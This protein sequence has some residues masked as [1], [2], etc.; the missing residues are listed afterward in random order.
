MGKTLNVFEKASLD[1]TALGSLQLF[2]QANLAG[3]E[4]LLSD[5][6]TLALAPGEALITPGQP[7]QVVYLVLAGSLKV[8]EGAATGSP[9]GSIGPGECIGLLSLIDR[10]P[11]RVH[12]VCE[13]QC[14]LLALDEDRLLALFNTPTAI[15]RNALLILMQ[16]LRS[17]DHGAPERGQLQS[18]VARNSQV[19]LVTGIHNQRW[20]DEMVDRLILRSAKDNKP[21]SVMAVHVLG[22]EEFVR[23]FGCEIGDQAL[24]E[25]ARTINQ[26][27]RPTDFL[28][29]HESGDFIL[30]LTDTPL[31]GAQVVAERVREAVAGSEIEIP[32]ACRLPPLQVAIGSAQLKAFVAGRK[33]VN[34]AM[35][36]V[37]LPGNPPGDAAHLAA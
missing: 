24:S 27:V 3:L 32:G 9:I 28:A 17:K 2:Q 6:P 21:L 12:I 35:A 31:D 30:L 33:L 1:L 11:C 26:H 5:C 19:D 34:D 4:Y 37:P 14:R 25:V 13:R 22:F 7:N 29:R 20:L 8:F 18:R 15:A 16:Y 36:A 23:E 10:Q